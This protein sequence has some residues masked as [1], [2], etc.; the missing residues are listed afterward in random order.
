MYKFTILLAV[1]ITSHVFASCDKKLSAYET[2]SMCVEIKEGDNW[3]HDYP[4]FLGIKKKNPPQIAIWIE[5]TNGMYVSTVYVS[6]KAA[7]GGWIGADG[8]NRKEALPCWCHSRGI[9]NNDGS[10]CPTKDNPVTDAMTGATPRKGF[11][12]YYVD[13]KDMSHYYVMVEVNHSTDFND[14]YTKDADVNSP[15]YSGGE[16]GSGQP[17]LIYK[18]EIDMASGKGTFTASLIGHSSP[19]GSDGKVHTDMSGISSALNIVKQI[20][21]RLK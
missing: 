14:T 1:I 3:L 6:R 11:D 10:F 12:T 19:D 8:N 18:A 5:D 2:G 16:D 17:A 7:T 15:Y 9:R 4:L 21:I 20:N 13:K